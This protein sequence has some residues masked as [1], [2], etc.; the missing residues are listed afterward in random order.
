MP[1]IWDRYSDTPVERGGTGAGAGSVHSYNG[2]ADA[3]R[4]K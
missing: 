4:M 3:R 2:M 1:G